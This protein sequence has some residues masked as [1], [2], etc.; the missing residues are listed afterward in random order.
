[1]TVS[2]VLLCAGS[3]QRFGRDKL[4]LPLGGKPVWRWAYEALASHPEIQ[5]V[6]VVTAPERIAEFEG[7]KVV[8][9]GNDRQQSSRNGVEACTGDVVLVHDGARPFVSAEMIS[10]VIAGARVQGCGPAVPVTDT[11]RTADQELVDRESLRAMQTPQ[12]APK[13]AWLTALNHQFCGMTDDLSLLQASGIPIEL[14]E[15]DPANI[16][17][18]TES[19]YATALG[20]VGAP[21]IRT[22]FGYDVHAFSDDPDRPMW[23]GG[24]EFDHR[25]GLMGHSDADV[26]LHAIADALLGALALGDIGVLFPNTDPAFK[27]KRSKAFVEE[28]A[29]RVRERGYRCTHVDATVIAEVPKVMVRQAEIRAAIAEMIGISPDRV[30]V[31]ATTHERLGSLGRAE[32]IAA[33]AVATVAQAWES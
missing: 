27:D 7:V 17:I 22:G 16:K 25:P 15:G 31:K 30:S 13:S 6:I 4:T 20:R 2:A 10:R 29:R 11:I 33:M 1:M 3:S 9:G 26:L 12:G 14:V 23:L 32:G 19:D 28:A 8:P 21:E 18:T 24:V 5:E